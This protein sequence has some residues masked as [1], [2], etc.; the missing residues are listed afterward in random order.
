MWKI[1]LSCSMVIAAAMPANAQNCDGDGYSLVANP[2]VVAVGGSGVFELDGPSMNLALLMGS[3]GEGP[4]PSA[5]GDICLDFPLLFKSIFVL[6]ANGEVNIPYTVP[7]DCTLDGMTIYMQ[8]IV[9]NPN[10]GRSNQESLT[11]T[12]ADLGDLPFLS[13]VDSDLIGVTP[14]QLIAIADEV[15]S[16]K[17]GSCINGAGSC[18]DQDIYDVDNNGTPD[19]SITDLNDALIAFNCNFYNCVTDLGCLDI[20][21]CASYCTFIPS[22]WGAKC[23]GNN[24]GCLRDQHFATLFPSGLVLG[25]QDGIDA[26]NEYAVLLTTAAAVEILFRDALGT[27]GTFDSDLTDPNSGTSAGR[28]ARHLLAAKLNVAFDDAGITGS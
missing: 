5:Y 7:N 9:C 23:S 26:D 11:I 17:Y 16:G 28:F 18:Q 8:F 6:D 1:A 14:R 12:D 27:Q 2:P 20:G 25:D 13:C 3:L 19:V 24:P 10:K 15:I 21:E 22:D 4:T